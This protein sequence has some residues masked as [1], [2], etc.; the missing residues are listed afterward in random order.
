MIS[1]LQITFKLILFPQFEQNISDDKAE[2]EDQ[3]AGQVDGD[4]VYIN[5]ESTF[6]RKAL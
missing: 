5:E 6:Q 3:L 1:L 2:T 4:K